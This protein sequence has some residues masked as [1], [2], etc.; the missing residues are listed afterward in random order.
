MGHHS[1]IYRISYESLYRLLTALSVF[2][3]TSFLSS[4]AYAD[5]GWLQSFYLRADAGYS[6]SIDNDGDLIDIANG[7]DILEMASENGARYQVG[8]GFQHNEY[9]RYDLTVSYRDD[10]MHLGTY[11]DNLNGVTA[12]NGGLSTSNL[13]TMLNAYINP[14]ELA[15][16]HTGRFSPYLQAGVGWARNETG[17]AV[18]DGNTLKGATNNDFAWQVGAG[19]GYA[20]TDNWKI[21]L[22]YRFLDMGQAKSSKDVVGSPQKLLRGAR[23]DL[24]AHEVLIGLR[25]QF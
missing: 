10:L 3:S 24:Q 11:R 5:D 16:I 22:S 23:F 21:D 15:E 18:I 12:I 9:L 8:I 13:T 20:I 4:T 1:L 19:L 7:R 2:I 14:M 17:N 6:S 25:Y